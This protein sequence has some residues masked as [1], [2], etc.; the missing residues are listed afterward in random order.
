MTKHLLLLGA[1]ALFSLQTSAQTSAPSNQNS[2]ANTNQTISS[3]VADADVAITANVTA[4][5]LKYEI[6]PTPT[7]EFSGK[8]Q[9]ETAWES[10]RRNLPENVQPGVTYRDIGIRL[11]IVSRFA[12][13][14]R[15]VSEALGEIPASGE[16]SSSVN[17]AENSGEKTPPNSKNDN[18]T[19]EPPNKKSP[20]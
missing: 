11:R 1:I 5:E 9:R 19:A 15:I 16:Q 7:V 6:V 14:D 12:D 10:E 17:A 8:P 3:N 13:I 2:S 18:R 4:K 20:E